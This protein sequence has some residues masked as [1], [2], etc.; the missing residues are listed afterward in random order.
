MLQKTQPHGKKTLAAMLIFTLT[1]VLFQFTSDHIQTAKAEGIA[2]WPNTASPA[3]IQITN[4]GDANRTTVI[5][6]TDGNYITFWMD[7]RNANLDIFAQKLDTE[8]GSVLWTTNGVTIANTANNESLFDESITAVPDQSGGAFIAWHAPSAG[9]SNMGIWVNHIST[10]GTAEWTTGLN[11]GVDVGIDNTG[12]NDQAYLVSDNA[13][14]VFVTW[15]EWSPTWTSDVAMTR[16]NSSGTVHASWNTGGA[17]TF[18]P[19]KEGMSPNDQ[20]PRLVI[21]S[22]NRIYWT[23]QTGD[24]DILAVNMNMDGYP[25]ELFLTKQ[26]SEANGTVYDYISIADNDRG[27]ITVYRHET[28]GDWVMTPKASRIDVNGEHLWGTFDKGNWIAGAPL[29]DGGD[30]DQVHRMNAISDGAGG[31]IAIWNH[32][33]WSSPDTIY[34]QKLDSNGDM[35]WGMGKITVSNNGVLPQGNFNALASDNTG[36]AV[37]AYSTTASAI[38]AQRILT[39]GTLD[40]GRTGYPLGTTLSYNWSPAITTGS[41]VIVWNGD[42][43]IYAQKLDSPEAAGGDPCGPLGPNQ[44]C[45]VLE[46]TPGTLEIYYDN[47]GSGTLA[48]FDLTDAAGDPLVSQAGKQDAFSLHSTQATPW[49]ATDN[50]EAFIGVVDMTGTEDAWY[51]TAQVATAMPGA[52]NSITLTNDNFQMATSGT[53]WGDTGPTLTDNES[54]TIDFSQNDDPTEDSNDIYYFFAS[55]GY[56][57][58]TGDVTAPLNTALSLT[59]P[60]TYIQG[61]RDSAVTIINKAGTLGYTTPGIF[62]IAANYYMDV[63]T[64]ILADTYTATI[65]YTLMP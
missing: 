63:T 41:G 11:P 23:Y 62:G 60:A 25:N 26:L 54:T 51:L 56:T 5:K 58:T 45:G 9:G 15:R 46:L 3:D 8:D 36:G 44:Q 7:S 29:D 48:G 1:V 32:D 65:T 59:D 17:G 10:T 33:E 20:K 39:D 14:G 57:Y 64:G 38:I 52:N 13:G 4:L 19:S 6:A 49:G 27:L 30:H 12:E 24:N 18:R 42:D 47:Y 35:Q 16:L 21:S 50:K 28:S 55:Q 2:Q 43:D 61:I 40:W 34:A 22:D 53:V 31:I 37:I